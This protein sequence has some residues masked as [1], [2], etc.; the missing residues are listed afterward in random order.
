MLLDWALRVQV[1]KPLPQQEIPEQMRGL[2]YDLHEALPCWFWMCWWE[3]T[4][5][6][7]LSSSWY[8]TR[9]RLRWSQVVHHHTFFVNS[10]LT[11]KIAIIYY[12]VIGLMN[13]IIENNSKYLHSTFY[14]SPTHLRAL[15][16]VSIYLHNEPICEDNHVYEETEAQCSCVTI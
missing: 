14:L 1:T 4:N 10:A 13:T 15:Y 5:A 9:V 3:T 12:T 7:C 11:F 8:K 2:Q 16:I 6:G